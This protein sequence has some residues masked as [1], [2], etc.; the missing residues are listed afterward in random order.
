MTTPIILDNS[1]GAQS[2]LRLLLAV[3]GIQAPSI[4][5][6]KV[7]GIVFR[8]ALCRFPKAGARDTGFTVS[9]CRSNEF[10]HV[11]GDIFVPSRAEKSTEWVHG[12]FLQSESRFILVRKLDASTQHSSSQ[13][14]AQEAY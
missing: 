5:L 6:Q 4:Q 7:P 3:H 8:L 9:R 14:S 12:C 10:H 11:Q 1:I 2:G 13:H